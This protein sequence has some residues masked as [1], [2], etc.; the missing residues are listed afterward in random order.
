MEDEF[1]RWF[2]E[3]GYSMS[4]FNTAVAEGWTSDDVRRYAVSQGAAGPFARQVWDSVRQELRNG[5]ITDAPASLVRDIIYNG[6]YEDV[7]Y[8]T[9]VYIPSLAGFDVTNSSDFG[10]FADY[11]SEQ[12][13]V[14]MSYT[15]L[16]WLTDAIKQYGVDGAYAR[17]QQWV[18]TT[19]SA[20][21]GNLGA[22]KRDDITDIIGSI[23]HRAPTAEELDPKGSLWNM[24]DDARMEY[25]RTLP[26]Y[27]IQYEGKPTWM[28][29]E[30]YNAIS[31]AFDDAYRRIYG[32]QVPML[33]EAPRGMIG[34]G[35]GAGSRTGPGGTGTT[36]Q[37][38]GGNFSDA[39]TMPAWLKEYYLNNHITPGMLLQQAAWLED[40]E[41]MKGILNPQL[42]ET[43]GVGFTDEELYILASGTTGTTRTLTTSP[44]KGYGELR[45]RAIQAQNTIQFREVFRNYTGR[46][47]GPSDYD[48]L[49]A[50]FIS[51]NEYARRMGAKEEAAARLPEI[52]ELFN[53]VY[54]R[55]VSQA[56][57]ENM[58]MGGEG[59]GALQAQINQATR[60]D[61]YRWIH[62]QYYG[63][64]PTA[65]DYA[66]YAG[67]AGPNELLHQISTTEKIAEYR[68]DLQKLWQEVYQTQLSEDQLTTLFGEEKGYGALRAQW[69]EAKKKKSEAEIAEDAAHSGA[70]G[71]AI[72]TQAKQGGIKTGFGSIDS[73]EF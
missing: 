8:F 1:I 63:V 49:N 64:E 30:T 71:T 45:V 59:S 10:R 38:K 62:K 72:I 28:D 13:G 56:E 18:P 9:N 32:I 57:L 11:W 52:N 35:V 16:T 3:D 40:A 65:S 61:A 23:L 24:N 14:P 67:F 58:A 70:R 50:N 21:N 17:W 46:D 12:T 43:T 4:V 22:A 26:D 55:S 68:D 36:D 39:A 27:E 54:G 41:Y 66:K 33:E 5:G 53:R 44:A 47:P 73:Q 20:I 60:L 7:D 51:P 19:Y 29:E 37:Q 15:A 31:P 48:Y 6:Y 34:A 2:G 69:T 25:L 42:I